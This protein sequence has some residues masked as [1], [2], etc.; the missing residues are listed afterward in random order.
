MKKNI[1]R[2]LIY[3]N[4]IL[5]VLLGAYKLFLVLHE[6]DFQNRNYKNIEVLDQKQGEDQFSFVVLGSVEN[7]ISIF[8]KRIIN[9]VNKEE[10]V[11]FAIAPGNAV[12]DGAEEKYR[13]L[14]NL[15]NRL[16]MP[17]FVGFGDHELTDGGTKRYY[18][19]FGPYYYAFAYS[20]SYFIFVDTTGVTYSKMQ[21]EWI[22][23]ELQKADSYTN[24]F[25][26]VNNALH[27]DKMDNVIQDKDFGSYLEESFAA[28]QV[29]YV[30]YN[31][32]K[33]TSEE[34]ENGITYCS[35]G[36]A[37]ISSF[38]ENTGVLY[39]YFLV[40]VNGDQIQTESVDEVTKASNGLLQRA[41]NCAMIIE[42]VIYFHFINFILILLATLLLALFFYKRISKDVDY[43]RSF[44]HEILPQEQD[45]KLNI[46]MFTNNYLPYIGGVPISVDLLAKSLRKRGHSVKVFAPQYPGTESDELVYR[47]KGIPCP[48]AEKFKLVVPNIFAWGIKKEFDRNAFDIV[49]VHHPFWMGAK[50]MRLARKSGKP[51]V[52]TYHTRFEMYADNLPAFRLI[53]KNVISHKLIKNF[54]QKC[55]GIIAPT[56]TASE[57]LENVGV[58]RKKLVMPTG[59]DFKRYEIIEPL[60]IQEIKNTYAPNGEILLC[61][62]ARLSVEKNIDFMIHSL[63]YVKE[64]T[65]QRF[66]C[67]LIGTG[68]EQE[69]IEQLIQELG[70]EREVRLTGMIQPED[71]PAYYLAS[72]FFVF[73]SKSETQ[74]M[75]LLEAMA[76][77]CPVVAINASG[78]D[79]VIQDEFNGFKTQEEEVVWAE[80]VIELLENRELRV[81]MA[82]NA[83]HYSEDFSM[84]RLAEEVEQFYKK[85]IAYN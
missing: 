41:G 1:L 29:D 70:L 21:K 14:N 13:I 69:H 66:T 54:G 35:N 83:F 53:F 16:D 24:V 82:E 78:V 22:K 73:S 26:F 39:H 10:S 28:H 75:V 44:E 61:S 40:K 58:S 71:I 38:N 9:M 20:N 65:D 27:G 36:N 47:C 7:T 49:H 79:D 77:K 11:A 42:S 60:Q 50:G 51:V 4:I 30:F 80:K 85:I 8:K 64:H 32:E 63:A 15:L 68:T 5:L 84:D 3:L 76:G 12:L 56:I 72:D 55:K 43:Y 19:H 74:G 34:A 45:K 46:A 48:P 62:V 6:P 2:K 31:G 57:Y 52:L 81:Q 37:G 17:T 23:E 59:I 67:M 18:D 33:I 25:V